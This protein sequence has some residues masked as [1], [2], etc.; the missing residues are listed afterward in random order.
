MINKN[1][2]KYFYSLN[3]ARFI[4]TY[5]HNLELVMSLLTKIVIL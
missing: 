5:E 4:S 3:L 1:K 2:S